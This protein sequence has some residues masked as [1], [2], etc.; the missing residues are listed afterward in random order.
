MGGKGKSGENRIKRKG[1]IKSQVFFCKHPGS[2]VSVLFSV[3]VTLGVYLT[4]RGGYKTE[5]VVGL[6]FERLTAQHGPL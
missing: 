2:Q 5:G 1:S 4:G 3:K 6:T